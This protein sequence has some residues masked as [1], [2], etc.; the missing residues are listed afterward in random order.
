MVRR[1]ADDLIASS[2]AERHPPTPPTPSPPTP[3]SSAV[4]QAMALDRASAAGGEERARARRAAREASEER[5]E[6][7]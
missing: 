1:V 2:T 5:P 7:E 3:T 6:A 4:L